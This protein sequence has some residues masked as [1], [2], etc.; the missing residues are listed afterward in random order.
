[1]FGLFQC[2]GQ[3]LLLVLFLFFPVGLCPLKKGEEELPSLLE[4][5]SIVKESGL[6]LRQ[7]GGGGVAEVG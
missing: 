1:M 6:P 5:Q 2:E 3:H 4:L 7:W